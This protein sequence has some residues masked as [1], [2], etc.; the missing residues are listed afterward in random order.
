MTGTDG[1]ILQERDRRLM[2]ALE[3]MRIVDRDQVMSVAGFRSITRANTRLL[4]LK[5]A[6]L[7]RR[8]FVGSQGGNRKALYTLSPK[9]AALVGVRLWHLHRRQADRL[10]VDPFI[11]HQLMVNA[12][13][14]LICFSPLPAGMTCHGWQIFREP[15]AAALP[16][17]PD[18]YFEIEYDTSI[19]PIFLE[20][21]RGTEGQ[22]IWKNKTESYLRLAASGEFAKRFGQQRFR[23][24]VA[25]NSERRLLSILKT[26]GRLTDK[27]FWFTTFSDINNEGFWSRL[28]LRPKQDQK[29]SLF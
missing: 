21:D 5:N 15:I 24:L 23:V 28:W 3:T 26:V 25:V 16:I 8:L 2:T 12:L 6:G 18:G 19:H 20:V 14:I 27:I 1:L 29:L 9:G 11:E 22:R 13:R 10:V 7:L 4:K 17:A